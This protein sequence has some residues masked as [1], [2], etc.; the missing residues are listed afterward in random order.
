MKQTQNDSRKVL[1]NPCL[2]S[3]NYNIN[4]HNIKFV[5]SYENYGA[6]CL[7]MYLIIKLQKGPATWNRCLMSEP[8]LQELKK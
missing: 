2:L 5:I 6:C 4:M 1:V 7:M 8:V 3:T